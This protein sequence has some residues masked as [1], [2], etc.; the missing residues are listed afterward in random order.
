MTLSAPHVTLGQAFQAPLQPEQQPSPFVSGGAAFAFDPTFGSGTLTVHADLLDVGNLSLQGIGRTNF[1]AESGEIRGNGTFDAAGEIHLRSGQIYPTTAAS[2][3]IAATDR[4]VVVASSTSGSANVTL[5]SAKLPPGFGVG[6]QLLGSRVD[7]IDGATITLASGANASVDKQTALVFAP[8]SGSVSIDAGGERALPWSA[9]G[10]LNVYGSQITQS[11]VLRAPLGTINL[12]WNGTGTGPVDSITGH[13]VATTQHLTLAA[14]STTS[15]SMIDPVTGQGLTLPYGY[16]PL[17][18]AWI[19]PAGQDISAGGAPAKTVHLA[20]LNISQQAGSTIDLRGGGDLFAY[21]FQSGNGGSGDLLGTATISWTASDTYSAGTLVSYN[22]Q[23]FSAR[24]GNTGEA[25]STVSANWKLVPQAFAIVPGYQPDFAPYAPFNSSSDPTNLASGDPG[26]TG[27]GLAAGDRIYLAGSSSLAAGDYTLLP[28]RYALLPGA[29]LVTPRSGT[30]YGT[31]SLADGASLVPGY[32]FNDLSPAAV[33]QPLATQFELAPATTVRNRVEYQDF[34]ANTFLRQTAGEAGVASPR[35]PMDAGYLGVTALDGLTLRGSVNSQAAPQ[36][37]GA[38]I[39]ISTVADVTITG[40]GLAHG[41]S[42]IV[43]SAA[44]LSSFGAES[45]LIGGTRTFGSNEASI[46]VSTGHLTLDNAGSPLSGPEVI[47]VAKEALVLAPNAEVFAT[48]NGADTGETLTLGKASESGS[49]DGALLRVS[50][51]VGARIVRSGMSSSTAPALV[52]G[53]GA[54][55]TGASVTLDSTANTS[56]DPT[57]HLRATQLVLN[58]GAITLALS[59][60]GDL[61]T[62]TGLLLSGPVLAG[63]ESAKSLSL[64]S[65]ST[66]DIYGTGHVDLAPHGTLALH[67]AE[68]RGFQNDDGQVTFSAGNILLDNSAGGLAPAGPATPLS[69]TLAFQAGKITLGAKAYTIS[70]YAEIELNASRGVFLRGTGSFT[71]QGA[72]TLNTPILTGAAL[73]RSDHHRGRRPR[74]RCAG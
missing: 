46:R 14:G 17:G 70:R 2:F 39:D 41:H 72:L 69:G 55:I 5:A 19:N 34:F 57:A 18:S 13:T 74:P 64:L 23:T 11:G 8:G 42:G 27:R 33:G 16:N 60:A 63:L 53:A 65:Y 12:G 50:S 28:A 71:T 25:P 40:D 20:G 30:P 67:A 61:P 68:I 36:G 59:D 73:G 66:F 54:R 21:R 1:I 44:A 49:G 58:S 47:L 45:L 35:L 29:V 7:S 56:L 62:A 32:R 37:R 9:G 43:L 51:S 38:F 10:A 4:N 6:S 24:R 52:I 3:T 48:G 26:Y 31:V 22:G 15:V